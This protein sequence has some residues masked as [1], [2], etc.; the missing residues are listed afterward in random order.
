MFT[1]DPIG[2]PGLAALA[3]GM[4]SFV[5]AL[6]AA[7]SRREV[8]AGTTRSRASTLGIAV[9]GLGIALAGYGVQRVTLDPLS[10]KALIEALMVTLLI[11]AALGLF[12]WASR[13]MGRNWSIVARTRAD[14]ALVQSGPFARVRHPIYVAMALFMLALAFALGHTRQ[15]ILAAPLFALGTAMRVRIEET[16]LRTMFGAEYDSYADR[17]KRFIPGLF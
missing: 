5:I 9:Q 12:V 16:L 10:P 14:H 2:L 15:L 4:A 8:E 13:A 1:P 3:L 7:R 11:A 6:L 17:V